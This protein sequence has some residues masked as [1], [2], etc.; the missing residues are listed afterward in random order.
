L[1]LALHTDLRGT[2][3][4]ERSLERV[5]RL[6]R[7][8]VARRLKYHCERIIIAI[9]EDDTLFKYTQRGGGRSQAT[10][11]LKQS[12]WTAKGTSAMG[13]GV[14]VQLIG[15]AVPY[16]DVLEWGP[17]YK[18]TWEIKPKG[19]RS[20]VGGRKWRSGGYQALQFLSFQ[21]GNKVVFA[22][23]VTH[24]WTEKERRPHVTPHVEKLEKRIL[25]DLNTI[26][27]KVFS[28]ELR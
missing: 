24:R 4:F 21:V 16:G 5:P 7:G 23:K 12:L 15:W 2:K 14:Q 11:Q 18:R 22:R 9:K 28:G 10:G 20:D 8:H 6:I 1:S 25:K 27:S 3:E 26:P 13:S 17:M 19:F